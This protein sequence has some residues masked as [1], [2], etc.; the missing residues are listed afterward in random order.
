M[1]LPLKK[2]NVYNVGWKNS[3]NDWSENKLCSVVYVKEVDK[4]GNSQLRRRHVNIC[5]IFILQ[6]LMA[7]QIV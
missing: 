2:R 7:Q 6:F 1:V 3:Y 5:L 4:I